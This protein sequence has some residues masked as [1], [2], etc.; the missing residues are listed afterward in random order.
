MNMDGLLPM[1]T[2]DAWMEEYGWALLLVIGLYTLSLYLWSYL[3]KNFEV[4][5][6]KDTRYLDAEVKGFLERISKLAILIAL[7]V[8]TLYVS[9]LIWEWVDENIWDPYAGLVLDLILVA[10][11][12]LTGMLVVRIFRRLA[13]L[14]RIRAAS[15]G[16]QPSAVEYTSLA[17]SYLVY[18]MT[19][20]V[21]LIIV[22][23]LLG[24]DAVDSFERFLADNG[25]GLG[26]ILVIIAAAYVADRLI[27]TILEDYKFRTKK[28]TP[29]VIDMFKLTIRVTLSLIAFLTV[30]VSIMGMMD[31]LAA[32]LILAAAIII[33]ICLGVALS[34]SAAQNIVSGLALMDT[35]IFDIGDRVQVS[36]RLDCEIIEKDLVFT[37]VRTLEGEIVSVP[38]KEIIAHRIY[39]YTKYG[40]HGISLSF[41]ASYS[42]PH[43]DV[44][45][46]VIDA[47]SKV[48]NVLKDP[49]PELYAKDI[50]NNQIIYEVVVYASDALNDH[51][52]RSELVFRIQD[53]F[54]DH[55]KNVLL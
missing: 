44:E 36:G 6:T 53:T 20:V 43:R 48:S 30:A 49:K 8:S 46:Y 40:T 55:G 47:V 45:R 26:S 2:E 37:K 29:Q 34:Y 12:I 1:A 21:V 25:G 18:L 51:K 17:L 38:N 9:S 16:M 4:W 19:T 41:E 52:I 42:I 31:M 28:F 23:S 27:E 33:F 15:E 39:N 7:S 10:A 35:S 3:S 22:V 11:V 14:S 54:M 5:R 32:G 24:Y 13:R 50:R